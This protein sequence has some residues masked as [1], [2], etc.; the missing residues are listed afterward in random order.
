M[1]KESCTAGEDVA[2]EETEVKEFEGTKQNMVVAAKNEDQ[3]DSTLS[4]TASRSS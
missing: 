4:F 2:T 1:D 3:N